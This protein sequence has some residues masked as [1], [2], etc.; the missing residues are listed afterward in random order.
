MVGK[1]VQ[2]LT[3]TFFDSL[4]GKYDLATGY[5]AKPKSD[6]FKISFSQ[7][8]EIKSIENKL[9][10]MGFT[11]LIRFISHSDKEDRAEILIRSAIASMQQFSTSN[12]NSFIPKIKG[13]D[14]FLFQDFKN[15]VFDEEKGFILNIEEL[16]AI[17]HLP[18]AL[19]ETPGMEWVGSKKAEP[20][21]NVPTT[22]CTYIGYTSF[23]D[24]KI[25]FGISN[26]GDDRVRHMY[27]IGKSG[28]GK[29][30][31]F[32]NMIIQD[33]ANGFGVG[34]LDP[35]GDLIE[36]ILDYIPDDRI[37]DVVL[38]DPSD[39]EMPVGINLLELSDRS[40]KNLMASALISSIKSQ[41]GYS[42]GPRL[43]YLLNYCVLTLLDVPGTSILGI[44][45]LMADQNYQKYILHFVKDPVVIDFW[46]KE[47][48]AMKG[49]QRLITEAVAPIENKINRFLSSTTIRNIVGQKKS[50]VD[51]WDIMN[52]S[53]ILLLNLSKGKIGQDNANL[54]GALLVSRIQFM[55]MQRVKIPNPQDRKPF[56]LYVDEFQNFAGG[57]F[58]SILSESRKYKLGLYLTHQYTNQ[59]PEELLS[60]VFGNVG[61]IAAFGVGAPDAK[62][63]ETEFAPYFDQNDLISL[64]KFQIYMKLMI[65]GQ[66]SKPFSAEIFRP[67][68]P[69]DA[70][71]AK[72]TN[73][74]RAIENS[75]QTYGTPRDHVEEK[76]RKWVEFPFDKGKAVARE[77]NNK[78]KEAK[79][80]LLETSN[81]TDDIDYNEDIMSRI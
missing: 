50:T 8:Q 11:I 41:F 35:H 9:S 32:K 66:T 76:I 54:L 19:V 42:W 79:A 25:K 71:V 13:Q 68:L 64:Q 69:E 52:S 14:E 62:I 65:D 55:T 72:T 23:R 73:K 45:R 15:R 75:R 29:S 46:E 48:K 63:L 30:T 33:M 18:T 49:N 36:D 34:V 80:N 26:K 2:E 47:F 24:R 4:A 20:P 16:G 40:Q 43:E 31:Y 17:Y 3:R 57:E 67:W 74:V 38:V 27:L 59:L 1:E 12:L 22:D 5:G 60:A 53:K 78:D 10:K 37:N 81:A 51:I 70:I 61:T 6:V 28:T 58:E 44:T 77:Y 56:Y 21:F 39:T 7:E